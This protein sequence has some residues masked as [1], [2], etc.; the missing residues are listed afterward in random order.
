MTE[1]VVQKQRTHDHRGRVLPG[2][3]LNPT[4]RPKGVPN[5]VK[6]QGLAVIKHLIAQGLMTDPIVFLAKVY[7][8]DPEIVAQLPKGVK[9]VPID[10]RVTAAHHV[11]KRMYPELKAIDL[12]EKG[13]APVRFNVIVKGAAPGDSS[14]P[15]P[16][17]AELQ[18]AL[19]DARTEE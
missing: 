18:H 8:N 7:S 11:A 6:G 17:V 9:D 13:D 19:S 1:E 15:L 14:T 3:V 12:N 16:N 4:G 5:R 2:V 10:L